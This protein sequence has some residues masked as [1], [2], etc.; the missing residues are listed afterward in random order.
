MGAE[1]NAVEIAMSCLKTAFHH[2]GRVPGRGLDCAGLYI[3]VMRELGLAYADVQGYPRNPYDGQLEAQMDAQPSLERIPVAE[4]QAGDWLCMRI[5][6]A[7][8]HLALHA[9]FIDGIPYIVHA[10]EEHGGVV[11]HR[12]DDLWRARVMRAY[13]VK[14]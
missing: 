8:Q 9:G 10:S 7:P 14:V 3:H 11:H 2:Q 4:A 5:K 12:L 13:R 6:K 1:L